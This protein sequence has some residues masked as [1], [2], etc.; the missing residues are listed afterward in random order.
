MKQLDRQIKTIMMETIPVVKEHMEDVCST[1][2]L[3]YIKRLVLSLT[4][5]IGNQ[6][7]ARF[8]QRQLS[9]ILQDTLQK[10]HGRK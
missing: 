8:F 10:Y 6:E 4:S 9:S 5:Q 1:Q 3:T 2:L 7:F